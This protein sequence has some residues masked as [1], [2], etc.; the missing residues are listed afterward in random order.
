MAKKRLYPP[1]LRKGIFIGGLKLH[2]WAIIIIGLIASIAFLVYSK[3][4]NF[5]IF[6]PVTLYGICSI[7]VDEDENIFHQLKLIFQFLVEQQNYKAR[8]TECEGGN[9]A[10]FKDE[11]NTEYEKKQE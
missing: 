5:R 11:V 9:F 3:I 2:E 10:T 4:F 6:L 8:E 7:R 1:K